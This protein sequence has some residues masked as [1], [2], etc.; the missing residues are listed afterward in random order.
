VKAVSLG[1]SALLGCP[2]ASAGLGPHS[3]GMWGAYIENPNPLGRFVY[4]PG[5]FIPFP[6]FPQGE[7]GGIVRME[8]GGTFPA[9]TR[10]RPP[11]GRGVFVRNVVGPHHCSAG[12]SVS[13]TCGGDTR[14]HRPGGLAAQGTTTAT[15]APLRPLMRGTNTGDSRPA[16][17]G[18]LNFWGLGNRGRFGTRVRD[19][20]SRRGNSGTVCGGPAYAKGAGTQAFLHPCGRKAGIKKQWRWGPIWPWVRLFWTIY[21]G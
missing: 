20:F 10:A 8:E 11:A 17:G 14:E 5:G 2:G 9:K 21:R 19:Y 13:H 4:Y 18:C 12:T 16:G 1:W 7:F 6:K 3:W 15:P